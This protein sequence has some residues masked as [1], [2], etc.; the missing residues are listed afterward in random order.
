MLRFDKI[1]G[2]FLFIDIWYIDVVILYRFYDKFRFGFIVFVVRL[3]WDLIRF[4][5]FIYWN[6][7]KE[8]ME[9]FDI[10]FRYIL[11]YMYMENLNIRVCC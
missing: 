4:I 10:M 3:N 9:I 1:L 11:I 6:V 7:F 8:K 2:Y 5:M